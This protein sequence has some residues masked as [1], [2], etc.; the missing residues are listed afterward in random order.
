MIGRKNKLYGPLFR[1]VLLE[2]TQG[3]RFSIGQ[4]QI[5]CP[6]CGRGSVGTDGTQEVG[7]SRCEGFTCHDPGCPFLGGHRKGKQFRLTTSLLFKQQVWSMLRGLYHELVKEGAKG[8]TIAHV[9]GIS[10]AEVSHLRAG[11]AEVIKAQHGLDK[12]VEVPQPDTA[13]AIDE[14]FL[15]IEGKTVYV[16]IATGYTTHKTLG[17]R[18]SATRKEADLDEVFREAERNV[19]GGTIPTAS[20][21]AWAATQAMIANLRRP[22]TLVIHKHKPPYD[23]AVIRT[24]E[25]TPE[26]RV[27]TDIGV[28]V[29][30]FA[31][32][33]KR[34]F[35]H[36]TRR[37]SLNVPAPG[38]R[39]RPRGVKNGHGKKKKRPKRK[40]KR[41]RKGLF[42]VFDKGTKGYLRVDPTREKMRVGED[43]PKAVA[44]A[45]GVA[46]TLYTGLAIQNNLSENIN[47][48][49]QSIV[50]LKGPKT[51]ES[52]E[53]LLRATLI[54]RNDPAILDRLTFTR[55]LRAP[56][57]FRNLKVADFELLVQKGWKIYYGEKT[58]VLVN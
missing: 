2:T 56:F 1:E 23:R 50:R 44:A 19:A 28:K 43:C 15:K 55:R 3:H 17:V 51:I 42:V 26:E 16:I 7:S 25:Y 27:I 4:I 34:E 39:G 10:E 14:T 41:G 29:D 37:E 35:H 52:V 11:L 33:G 54:V 20:A 47:C 21:D 12:L 30:V 22:V 49:L 9:Y 53:K 5:L 38:P 46:F 8:K 45:L 13:V 58:E 32:R 48:V 57:F 36:M 31:R 40:Q 6:A 18:V 24:I